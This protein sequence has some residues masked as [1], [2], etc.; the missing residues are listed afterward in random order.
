MRL[1]DAVDMLAGSELV[2]LGPM[3]WADL[4]CGSG[5]FT[6]A[7]AGV[8]AAG[9]VIHAIDRDRSVLRGIPTSHKGVR[10]IPHCGEFTT[11]PWP[12]T[13]LDGIL[14]ANS[15]HYVEDQPAF[16]RSCGT[17]L[18]SARH[19]LVVEY[20]TNEAGPWVPYPVNCSRAMALFEHAGYR[21]VRVLRSRPSL[22][23][24]AP[25]YSLAAR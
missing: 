6:V 25:L 16:I 24:R 14:M 8:L 11:L 10:I 23:R 2:A 21:S 12:F 3:T 15:L 18:K 19:F 5:T 7:L 9:S 22:Y 17:Q 4:G 20:D 13:G 1:R